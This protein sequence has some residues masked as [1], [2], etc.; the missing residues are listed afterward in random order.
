MAF[1]RTTAPAK[2][3]GEVLEMYQRQQASWGYVPNYA[4]VFS[5]RP[6]IMTEWARLLAGIRRQVCGSC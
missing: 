3:Q 6:E 1:I 2:A 4:R 5:H